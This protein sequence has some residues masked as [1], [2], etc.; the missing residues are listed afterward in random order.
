MK[1]PKRTGIFLMSS[2]HDDNDAAKGILLSQKHKAAISTDGT[3]IHAV[4][5]N[6]SFN[7]VVSPT[8]NGSLVLLDTPENF[9]A[10]DKIFNSVQKREE[11]ASAIVNSDL[12]AE[13]LNPLD[14]GMTKL[15]IIRTGE[16]TMIMLQGEV[17]N[18][19]SFAVIMPLDVRATSDLPKWI[20]S[21]D[22]EVTE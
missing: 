20:P 7:C 2:T 17:D 21:T 14:K 18:Q 6:T 8:E 4:K 5:I 3:R 15:S 13:A 9:P 1:L 22:S 12:L 11:L 19:P 10:V 16:T